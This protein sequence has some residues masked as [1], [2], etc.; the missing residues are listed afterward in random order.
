MLSD[1]YAVLHALLRAEAARSAR[2]RQEPAPVQ[3]PDPDIDIDI[4]P[5]TAPALDAGRRLGRPP[6][7]PPCPSGPP[8]A[9]EGG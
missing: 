3:A 4:D 5:D 1:P 9:G 7:A 8:S 2:P 6:I